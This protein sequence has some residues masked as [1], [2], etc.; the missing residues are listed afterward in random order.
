MGEN[1]ICIFIFSLYKTASMSNTSIGSNYVYVLTIHHNLNL[2]YH[3]PCVHTGIICMSSQAMVSN[4]IFN[5]C[6][7]HQLVQTTSMPSPIGINCT[8][9]ITITMYKL[10]LFHHHPLVHITSM[11][12]P[13]ISLNC[14]L[15]N[16]IHWYKL[17]ICIFHLLVQTACW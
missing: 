6:H 11:F 12:L 15:V 3:H 14:I 10:H 17:Q 16:T 5:I 9:V 8:H 13:P 1:Y 4:F 7:L 2:F